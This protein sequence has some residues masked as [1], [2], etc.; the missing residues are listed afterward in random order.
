MVVAGQ[1]SFTIGSTIGC[2][3]HGLRF[4]RHPAYDILGITDLI[5]CE[6]LQG[7]RDDRQFTKTHDAL[8]KLHLFSTGGGEI[9]LAA[10]RNFRTLRSRGR[11]VKTIDCLIATFCIERRHALLHSDRDYDVFE[12]EL[13]LEIVPPNAAGFTGT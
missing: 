4:W 13:G 3:S 5:L 7:V 12:A 1:R 2:A 10:A 6:V 8:L 11:T 9:A